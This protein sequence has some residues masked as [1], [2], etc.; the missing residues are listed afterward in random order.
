MALSRIKFLICLITLGLLVSCVPTIP[1]PT[2]VPPLDSNAVNL[3][4]LQTSDAAS[5]QTLAALPTSTATATSTATP[6]YTY[7]PE[8]TLTPIQT[9]VFPTSTPALKVQYYRVKHDNQL[10]VF[11]YKSRTF[12]ANSDGIRRQTPEVFPLF[13]LP[14]LTSGT[15]RTNVSGAWEFYIE[16]LNDFNKSKIGYL[17]N[18]ETALFNTAGFP[19][20]ESLTMG[21]N[22]ITLDAVQNGWGQ[23]NTLDYSSPPNAETVNYFTRPDLVHK[24]VVVG[25]KRATKSTILVKPPKG[26]LYWPLVTRKPVW[27]QMDLL[28]AFPTLPME[29]TINKDVYVQE[30]P[31]PTIEKTG[32]Q[33]TA[34][35]TAKLVSYFPSGS[36]VW[37]MLSNGRWIP[38]LLY[39]Q[40]TTSWRMET[41]PPPP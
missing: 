25:W 23:V 2:P 24:F 14:K 13:I 10:A 30:T 20:L 39:P 12:D 11:D 41:I 31:G 8:P 15:L 21:G 32:R 37:G 3:Y 16:A 26:D 40:Y 28:E 22:I 5:L 19:Q 33:L 17:K 35:D 6:R 34:G 29:I 38:L 27:I 7:T 36:N 1:T 4:I 9:F 18:S